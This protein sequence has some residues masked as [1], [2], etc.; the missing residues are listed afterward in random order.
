MKL[1]KINRHMTIPEAIQ[2]LG[3]SNVKWLL[4]DWHHRLSTLVQTSW[5]IQDI[6]LYPAYSTLQDAGV[7]KVVVHL[8]QSN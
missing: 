4:E 3:T 1:E 2:I 7:W 8:G 6:N 5:Y